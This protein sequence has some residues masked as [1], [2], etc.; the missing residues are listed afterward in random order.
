MGASAELHFGV[1]AGLVAEDIMNARADERVMGAGIENENEIGKTID[2]AAGKFLLFIEAAFNFAAHGN[3]HE[4]A[5]VADDFSGVVADG[6]GG[7]EI[8]RASC[9]ERG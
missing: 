3:V 9:R 5:L 2:E 1:V 4:S 6:G 8:G 7:I